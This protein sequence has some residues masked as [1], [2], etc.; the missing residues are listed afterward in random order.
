LCS[1]ELASGALKEVLPEWQADSRAVY[2]VW[3][4]QRYLPAR[5]RELLEHLLAFAEQE[6]LLNGA[7]GLINK[8]NIL[9]MPLT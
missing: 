3:P 9:I 8:M 6:P 7:E 1:E 4:Q 2:A 5:V